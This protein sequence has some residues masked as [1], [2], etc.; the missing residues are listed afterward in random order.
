MPAEKKAKP[1]YSHTL[2]ILNVNMKDSG[3]YTCL[4]PSENQNITETSFVVQSVLTPQIV[5]HSNTIEITDNSG[6]PAKLFCL[7]EAYPQKYF[8]NSIKWEKETVDTVDNKDSTDSS[9]INAEIANRTKIHYINSTHLEV[10]VEFDSV[11]KKH[12]GTYVC[13]VGQSSYMSEDFGVVEKRS[14]ILVL[15]VPI[16][17]IRFERIPLSIIFLSNT[18]F[19]L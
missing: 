2:T 11:T 12:N 13:S 17:M 14:T 4:F 9:Q 3:N 7:I 15:S 10:N 19:L 18:Q 16:A 1:T 6:K 8:N 5:S